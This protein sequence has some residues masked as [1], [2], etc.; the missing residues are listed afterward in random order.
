M[1]TAITFALGLLSGMLTLGIIFNIKTLIGLNRQIASLQRATKGQQS[2][3]DQRFATR[4]QRAKD[5]QADVRQEFDRVYAVCGENRALV[6]TL[7]DEVFA[8]IARVR[9]EINKDLP[10]LNS[11]LESRIDDIENNLY[12]TNDNVRV[13]ESNVDSLNETIE[14]KINGTVDALCTRMDA[15]SFSKEKYQ[16]DKLNS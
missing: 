16:L 15:M 13:I 14:N 6:H 2:D 10:N 1:E 7:R 11:Y 12:D 9:D 3:C 4:D 8:E 5:A